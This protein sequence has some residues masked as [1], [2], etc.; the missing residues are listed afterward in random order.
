MQRGERNNNYNK[1]HKKT[2]NNTER[3]GKGRTAWPRKGV[4]VSG[5]MRV[6]VAHKQ[7][8]RHPNNTTNQP[9]NQ[10]KAGEQASRADEATAAAPTEE[11]LLCSFNRC[12][13]RLKKDWHSFDFRLMLSPSL[14]LPVPPSLCLSVDALFH[15][16][17]KAH[18]QVNAHHHH[19]H[20][21]CPQEL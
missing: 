18:T 15:P 9:A 1:R 5:E 7:T 10:G 4:G 8:N 13:L 3:K 11:S 6:D 20:K 17:E 14:C 21:P 2:L 12:V 16:H 19:R